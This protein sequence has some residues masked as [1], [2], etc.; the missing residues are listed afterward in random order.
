MLLLS[1]QIPLSR[2]SA[3]VRWRGEKIAGDILHLIGST[4]AFLIVRIGDWLQ[5]E[6]SV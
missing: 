3:P 1:P 6:A 4:A 5:C 2:G